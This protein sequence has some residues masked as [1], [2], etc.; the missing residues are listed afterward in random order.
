LHPRL[1]TLCLV[2]F[3]LPAVAQSN[4][5][6]LSGTIADPQSHAIAGAKVELT[7]STTGAIRRT[8]TN[9]QGCTSFR[10]CNLETTCFA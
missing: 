7:S 10:D 5:A 6:V 3:S 4:Y 8:S 9:A 2:L 1:A